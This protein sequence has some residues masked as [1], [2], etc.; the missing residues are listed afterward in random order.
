ML[1]LVDTVLN[2]LLE[3][4]SPSVKSLKLP[5]SISYL[6][7]HRTNDQVRCVPWNTLDCCGRYLG[8]LSLVTILA[9]QD[10]YQWRE[11]KGEM[12]TQ[13]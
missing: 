12:Q 13:G 5:P 1:Q 7:T 4:P 6:T 10:C 3:M 8:G 9:V 2:H 11:G